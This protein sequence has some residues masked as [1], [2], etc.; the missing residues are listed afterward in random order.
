MNTSKLIT[1]KLCDWTAKYS[2]H[3][4]GQLGKHLKVIHSMTPF[5]YMQQFPDTRE[6]WKHLSK[7]LDRQ[8]DIQNNVTSQIQCLECGELFYKLSQTHLAKHGMTPSQ[9]KAKHLIGS[10]ASV[11]TT[12]IQS[13]HTSKQNLLNPT[14][15]KVSSDEAHF[16]EQL[17]AKY[18]FMHPFVLEGRQYD[19]YIPKFNLI[20]ELDGIAFHPS[21]I[22]NLSFKQVK[23]VLNDLIKDNVV[24][25]TKYKLMRIRY[26]KTVKIDS[27]NLIDCLEKM[28]YVP[29]REIQFKTKIMTKEFLQKYNSIKGHGK[30]MEYVPL[31]RKLMHVL[32]PTIPQY[33]ATA[34]ISSVLDNIRKHDGVGIMSDCGIS[35]NGPTYGTDV[36]KEIVKS[37]WHEKTA[38]NKS[39]ADAWLDDSKLE[40][41]IKYRIG[42]NSTNETFDLTFSQLLRGL[43]VQR[44]TVSNFKP[45]TAYAIYKHFI[46][47]HHPV[48]IDPCA[49][50]GGRM[51]GFAAAYP[52]GVYYGVEAD[53]TRAQE[54]RELAKLLPCQI[55][56][57]DGYFEDVIQELPPIY[58]LCF[59]SIPYYKTENYKTMSRYSSE[60][61]W[62]N[63]FIAAIDK[64]YNKVINC[65][66]TYSSI[67]NHTTQ[68]K[69]INNKSPFNKSQLQREVLL[70]D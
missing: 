38:N 33:K 61:D 47:T 19:F 9:Y 40:R 17:R 67:I 1:C 27:T 65:Y 70:I 22:E 59:T 24:S 15:R 12:I 32:S 34:D 14:I 60:D 66:D 54:L 39:P 46:K 44:Y 51:I 57:I 23:T 28:Q 58:D 36:I 62:N 53:T 48:V 68:L 2:E 64:C 41:V 50:F 13:A 6:F 16:A 26:D 3:R 52:T 18:D 42:C 29:N 45:I 30:L 56:I 8:L 10:T 25:T 4:S 69:F 31:I 37:Y 5:E 21:K 49:G 43:S 7:R 63:T 35:N 55:H 11:K 20:V